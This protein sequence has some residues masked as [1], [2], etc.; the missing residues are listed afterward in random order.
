MNNRNHIKKAKT[1]WACDKKFKEKNADNE[2]Y[3]KVRC[4]CQHHTSKYIGPAHSICNLR[5]SLAK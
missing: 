4:H 5:Y 3:C 2:K 1:G